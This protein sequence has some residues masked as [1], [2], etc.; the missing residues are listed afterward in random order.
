MTGKR[1]AV[2][3]DQKQ[4]VIIG[5]GTG[6]YVAAIRGAQLGARVTLVEEA[7]V[8]GLCLN[9]GCIPSKSL[10]ACA[11]LANKIKKADEFGITVAGPVSYDLSRMVARKNKIVSTLVKG[12]TALLSAWK[13]E[14][15][16]GKATLVD[17]KQV[18]VVKQDGS[19]G[20]IM[21]DSV[22]LATGTTP[23][24]LPNLVLDGTRVISSREALDLTAIP[25]SL[26]IVG[27]GSEGCE[28]A[29]LFA[30]L[31]TT[32]TIV[33][34]LPRLLP[35]EDE[36]VSSLLTVELKKQGITILTGTRVEKVSVEAAGVTTM[37]STGGPIQSEKV[38]V[39]VG[40]RFKTEGLGLQT[41]GVTLGRRG[42]I[43]V[44]ERMQTN[45]PGI[46][47][48]GDVVGKAMLAHVAS[49]Q[50]KVAVRNILGQPA[51][52]SYDVVPAGI[53]TFPEIGRVGLT[54]QEA[55]ERGVDI[56]IGKFRA[57]GL[58][59]AHATGETTG[60]MK[61]ITESKTKKILGVHLVGAHAADLVH[62]A[63]VAMQL[64]ATAEAIAETI[65]AHPTM[66]E[67]LMEAA[68]DVE[69][70]AIHLARRR[71]SS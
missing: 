10:L 58:G 43:A 67:G 44:N 4:I 49:A 61:I 50:G 38:L 21:P 35:G 37:L 9:W 17:G 66:P 2:M 1:H 71:V 18:R 29:S 48:I 7:A 30:S 8:G 45:I 54:E 53:F 11:E 12:I 26:L 55:R 5:A 25:S 28:F 57:I 46:F 63:A 36:E 41:A 34:M 15:I 14:L 51:E 20:T 59:K 42:E 68:E 40:R 31:G 56:K 22:V 19:D 64:G 32:I 33:E 13:V 69:A 39:S 62:E 47:A 24:A 65:H 52:M 27:G 23:P 70:M 16:Q 60:M 6:G 3:P